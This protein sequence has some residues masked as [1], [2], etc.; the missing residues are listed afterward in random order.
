MNNVV[1]YYVWPG[2]TRFGF[3]AAALAGQEATALRATAAFIITDPGCRTVGLL[4]PVL[5]SLQAAGIKTTIFEQIPTNPTIASVDAAAAAFRES[6]ANIIIGVGGGSALDAAKGVREQAGGPAGASIAEYAL[7]LGDKARPVPD[8]RDMPPMI[9]IPTTAGTGAEVTPW[10]VLTEEPTKLKK[11]VGGP[12]LLPTVALID[13]EMTMTLP[14]FLTAAT[15][16]D[17]LSHCVEAFVSTNDSPVA[18]DPLILY[19]ITILGRSLPLAVSQPDNRNARYEVMMGAMLGGIAISSRWLGACHSLAHPLS[20][21]A[22][23]HHGHACAIMLPY[24]ME[25]NLPAAADRYAQMATPLGLNSNG[26]SPWQ[27]AEQ[28]IEAVH[29]LNQTLRLPSRLRDAGVT[30]DMIPGMV[31]NACIDLSWTTNPRTIGER[32]MAALYQ[33]AF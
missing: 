9:A 4:K 15:G 31:R 33:K 24:I 28:A 18:L 11:G 26:A 19:G 12:A 14:P 17:A 8:V 3:G 25:Y 27:Q 10:A 22:N 5:A 32:D 21:F 6:G 23:V 20:G 2:Q 16:M 30:E 29:R 1:A 7:L 13:P